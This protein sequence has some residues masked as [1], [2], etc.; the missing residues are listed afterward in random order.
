MLQVMFQCLSKLSKGNLTKANTNSP[1]LSM[2]NLMQ[3]ISVTRF[4]DLLDFG[5]LFKV[6]GNN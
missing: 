3:E 5:L 1:I 2:N 4:G 6:I